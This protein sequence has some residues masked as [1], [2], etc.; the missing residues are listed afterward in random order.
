MSEFLSFVV[1]GDIK[2][3]L[4]GVINYH[5]DL[6]RLV[7]SVLT[8]FVTSAYKTAKYGFFL[9]NTSIILHIRNRGN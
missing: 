2:N 4:L 1:M 3:L 8:D 7:V 5:S 9:H 6:S